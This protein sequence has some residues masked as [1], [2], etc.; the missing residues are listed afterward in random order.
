MGGEE[1]E[2]SDLG[3]NVSRRGLAGFK[4][5][6]GRMMDRGMRKVLRKEKREVE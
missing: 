6:A 5:R 4:P 2:T 1:G 3:C